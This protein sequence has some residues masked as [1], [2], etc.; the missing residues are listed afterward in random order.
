MLVTA[1]FLDPSNIRE[2]VYATCTQ[3]KNFTSPMTAV[4]DGEFVQI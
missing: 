4:Y 1:Q 3:Q 2:V